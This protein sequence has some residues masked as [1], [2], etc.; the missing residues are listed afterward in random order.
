VNF[1]KG[2]ISITNEKVKGKK[3]KSEVRKLSGLL[4]R[5]DC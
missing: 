4:T 2:G 1:S 3:E 5:F